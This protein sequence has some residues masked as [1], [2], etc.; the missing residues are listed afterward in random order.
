MLDNPPNKSLAAKIKTVVEY[1]IGWG[2][3]VFFVGLL[4]VIFSFLGTIIC[5]ALAGLMMGSA[6][7]PRWW[8]G[9][10][11]LIFPGVISTVLLAYR[12]ELPGGQILMLCLL[13]A[14]VFWATYGVMY[15]LSYPQAAGSRPSSAVSSPAEAAA[16]PARGVP[17]HLADPPTGLQTPAVLSL[18]DLQGVWLE[19]SGA[20]DPSRNLRRLEIRKDRILLC[21]VD[22]K[23]EEM[24]RTEAQLHLEGS[25]QQ[26]P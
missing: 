3:V 1:V 26:G 22:A 2:V 23:G 15:A 20:Q 24:S 17:A 8:S 13:C 10:A 4:T 9:L 19:Q 25:S 12:S 14:G 21:V 18:E 7:V 5:A 6:R 11:S 16:V